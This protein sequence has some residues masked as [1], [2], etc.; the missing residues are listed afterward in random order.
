MKTIITIFLISLLILPFNSNAQN[1][2]PVI[3]NDT[4]YCSAGL[5]TN[6]S[7]LINDYDL[8][9]D[10]FHIVLASLNSFNGSISNNDSIITLKLISNATGV[11]TIKYRIRDMVSGFSNEGYIFVFIQ[12]NSVVDTLTVNNVN[13]VF[14]PFGNYFWDMSNA[15]TY[16]VPAT[17]NTSTIFT[18]V[19]WIG[20]LDATG[21]LHIAAERYR[22]NGYDYYCG[23][24]RD[25]NLQAQYQD[26]IWNRVW[27]V[28]KSE[29]SY[30]RS[31]Y[32][33]SNYTP[34]DAIA[35]WPAMGDT[36]LGQAKYIAPFVDID[37]DGVYNPMHGDYPNIKG[38]QSIFMVFN[39]SRHKHGETG[40]SPMDVEFHAMAYAYDCPTDPALNGTIFIHYDIVNL[41]NNNYYNTFF[42]LFTDF[43]I[44]Y[45]ND[46]Y[47]GCDTARNTYFGYNGT[48]VDGLGLN[49]HYGAHPP[50]QAV[51]SLSK[52]LDYFLAMYNP[53]FGSPVTQDPELASE[54]Y[55]NMQGRW[56][57]STHISFGGGGYNSGGPQTNFMFPD[58]TAAGVWTEESAGNP[59]GDRRGLGSFGPF[60]FNANTTISY[61][62][63]YIYARDIFNTRSTQLLKLYIDNIQSYYENDTTPCG[64]NFSSI[65]KV[66]TKSNSVIVYPNPTEDN[67]FIE[68]QNIVENADYRIYNLSGQ[69]LQSG[70]I[71]D[72]KFYRL[73]VS[74]ISA[75]FYFLVINNGTK[76]YTK[77]IVIK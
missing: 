76:V 52:S 36:A 42:S 72:T 37:N 26:S 64:G 61:D 9:G 46:D 53:P 31:H 23:P 68:F 63:A 29:I 50:A 28:S 74:S 13:A 43:D 69:L 14:A 10:P 47:I 65:N 7:P 70:F 34:I 71:K 48:V 51:T 8:D 5:S 41:S 75:G 60:T 77:K 20:G 59:P 57:D 45:A 39:D 56:K 33:Y 21:S 55:L 15:S 30:H 18:S 67:I 3:V 12:N 54:Y 25:T 58:T 22:G 38:D 27:K 66:K 62:F 2:V 24:K 35:N 73:N 49:N 19:P 44:G 17:S 4:V 32:W 1:S 16:N 6:I 11:D 40:G